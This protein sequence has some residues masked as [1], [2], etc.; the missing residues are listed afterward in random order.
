MKLRPL[1]TVILMLTLAACN[2]PG[3]PVEVA[4]AGPRAWVDVPVEGSRFPLGEKINIR[5]HASAVGGI[6]QVEVR[7]N[8]QVFALAQ[9]FDHAAQLVTQQYEWTPDAAGEYLIQAIATGMNGAVSQPAENRIIVGDVTPTPVTLAP[10]TATPIPPSLV[11]PTLAPPTI[12]PIP[13]TKKPIPPTNT[14]PPPADTQ[15][16]PAPGIILP[17]GN[18]T[19]ACPPNVKLVWSAPS[20]PSG[21]ASYRVQLQVK[22]TDWSNKKIWDPVTATQVNATGELTCGGVYRW[23]VA[24]RDGAGNL[25]QVS[26]WA[27]FGIALP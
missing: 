15:G 1:L 14:L 18:P 17:A 23:R 21:I 13:P 27:Y 3:S 2:L 20:D 16:P 22:T 7:I 24:A 25:G 11:P 26:E 6:Q 12:S 10:P 8:G 4:G 19:L 9:D 5:W